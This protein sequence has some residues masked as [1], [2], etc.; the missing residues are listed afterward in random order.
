MESKY[1]DSNLSAVGLLRRLAAIT[2]DWAIALLFS[3]AFFENDSSVTLIFFA[4][5][6]VVL[7]A[8]NSATIGQRL[9]GIRVVRLGAPIVGFRAAI[10]RTALE[11]L[12]LPALINTEAGTPLHDQLAKTRLVFRKR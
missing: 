10:I 5:M 9:L 7:I 2:I 3:G 1:P 4:A 6:R 8:T 11:L 12:V